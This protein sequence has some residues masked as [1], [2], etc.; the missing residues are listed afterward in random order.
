VDY[1]TGKALDYETFDDDEDDF[2]DL[3]DDEDDEGQ[4]DD[5]RFLFF[6]LL[7]SN[8][9]HLFYGDRT[10]ILMQHPLPAAE[11]PKKVAWVDPDLQPAHRAATSTRR[12]AR[13]SNW[14]PRTGRMA[15]LL[16][17]YL[18]DAAFIAYLIFVSTHPFRHQYCT[19]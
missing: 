12:N 2:E 4:F 5:V 6:V 16:A 8:V 18:I 1:F 7:H 9:T 13:P 17:C 15:N 3:D 19:P 10:L 14:L 11:G